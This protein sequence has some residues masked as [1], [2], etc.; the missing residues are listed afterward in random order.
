MFSQFKEVIEKRL[1]H[2]TET[3]NKLFVADVSSDLLWQT[4][5]ESFP[6]EER[7]GHTCNAC[8]GFIKNYGKLVAIKNNQT[9]TIWNVDVP[10]PFATVVKNL[11]ALVENAKV[12]SV[13]V[14]EFKKLGVDQ[15][16][17]LLDNGNIVTWQ[18]LF[19]ELPKSWVHS[20]GSSIEAAQAIYRDTKNVFYRSLTEITDEAVQ[21][22]LDLIG[23][24]SI[25]RGEEFAPMVV[26]FQA[27]KTAF[28]ELP[29]SAKE[30]FCWVESTT[31]QQATKRIRGTAIGT[32]LTD[33]SEG[34]D[35]DIAVAAFERIV[36]PTN[37]KRPAAVITKKMIE[38]AE[39]QIESLGLTDSLARRYAHLDDITVNNTLFVNRSI[40]KATGLLDT[41][42]DSITVNPK[43]FTKTEEVTVDTFINEILPKA[44]SIEVLFENKHQSR[45]MTLIA[46]VNPEAKGMFK[47][48]NPFSW[49]YADALADGMKER[50]K[51]AGGN[52]DGV[53]RFSIQWNEKS[54][55]I[56]DLDAHAYEPMGGQHIFFSN[57]KGYPT[58]QSGMLDVDM[59]RPLG[60][61]V[62]N[63]TWSDKSKM[64]YGTYQFQIHN[65][66]D[67]HNT[68]F[69]AQ[70]EV[71][72]QIH[73]FHFV[74]NF[75]GTL[76]IANVVY[77]KDGFEVV[78]RLPSSTTVQSKKVW[79]LDTF[80][81][82]PV[83]MVMRSPN[84]WDG[85]KIGN[86]HLFFI[87]DNA[88]NPDKPRGFFNEFLKD[89][90]LQ[91]KRVLETLGN[92]LPVTEPESQ[93]NGLGFSSTSK[94]EVIVKVNGSFSRTVKIKF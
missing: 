44:D 47:W 67:G 25:Y 19:F 57:Y 10:E 74:G 28:N 4:Y 56:C 85:Q 32:L 91:H 94:E 87:L 45:L 78:P 38:Q 75:K 62:E 1:Q 54:D 69:S 58:P 6:E 23:Q 35:L 48:N 5:I 14:P 80:Q 31:G 53:L 9:L 42:K 11:H 64:I 73:E 82:Q 8:R 30:N 49:S 77:S 21:V 93:L 51:A 50:V 12:S 79:N 76:S 90:L 39:K 16:K 71:D 3:N 27:L 36:A 41:L 70:V 2:L 84:Y 34:K 65:Y 88:K 66:D 61:G 37:Y 92:K 13:F 59:I 52:V 22:V 68:G 18:H 24:N 40:K 60:I 29:E 33:L 55:S 81:F 63:I 43:S 86:Q 15:N 26:E 7:Q 46:P 20:G 83:T 72:G 17:Q 89:D